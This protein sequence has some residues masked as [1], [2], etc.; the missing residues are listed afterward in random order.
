MTTPL[1]HVAAAETSLRPAPGRDRYIDTLRALAL[2]RVVTYHLLGWAWLPI[3]FPSMGVMFALAG[4]LAATSLS[5]AGHWTVLRKRV[6]RLLPPLWALGA[7]LV[8]VMIWRGWTH[9]PETHLGSAL[10]WPALVTW[11]VPVYTPGGSD[12]GEPY[13]SALWY[14]SAYLWLLL[15]S[16]ALLWLWRRWPLHTL[17]AP[18]LLL[19]AFTA[20]VVVPN[21]SR[22]DEM[23]LLL[24]TYGG[25]WLLGFAHAD[26]SLRRV[27]LRTAVPLA[28]ALMAAGAWWAL[29]HPHPVMGANLDV[30]P[31]ANGLYGLGFALLLLR[32][33]PSFGWMRR[34]RVL[35]ALVAAVNARAMTI[36]LWHNL[37]VG[38]ALVLE[39]RFVAGRFYAYGEDGLSRVVQ[40]A[41]VWALIAVAVL[42]LGWV[43]DV[44]ARRRPRLLP[45]S[46]S[47]GSSPRPAPAAGELAV[48]V[49]N[50]GGPNGEGEQ[51]RSECRREPEAGVPA[52]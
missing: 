19:V 38:V 3:L 30:I 45:W 32:C 24:A 15:L 8:P 18:L 4:G 7:V 51:H 43:E 49:R 21:G 9:D 34:R 40:Y 6:R 5:R 17:A 1:L 10:S 42:A 50:T 16:P 23:T 14:L 25:C 36:Y 11:V 33:A 39:A 20:G 31:F 26:G 12:W 48:L 22:T 47:R 28:L 41:V 27:R 52:R 29:T 13:T 46:G 35:D 44:A 2:V 37:A